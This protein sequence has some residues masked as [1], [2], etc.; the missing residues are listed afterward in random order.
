MNGKKIYESRN[1]NNR[2]ELKNLIGKPTIIEIPQE[3]FIIGKNIL[4]IRT[5]TI[6]NKSGFVY[7]LKIG[8]QKLI[9]NY[10]M[11]HII[12]YTLL[13]A[14]NIFIT[15]YFLFIYIY[16]REAF[17][18]HFSL[19]SLSL[20]IWTIGYHGLNLYL[21]DNQITYIISTYICAIIVCIFYITF[22]HSFLKISYNIFSYLLLTVM[23]LLLFFSCAEM[24]I[25]THVFHY[26]R[27]LFKIFILSALLVVFYGDVICIVGKIQKKPY[28]MRIFS[29]TF[30]L[31][32]TYAISI[33]SFLEITKIQPPVSEGFFLLILIFASTIAS[34]FAQVH[35]DL[36]TAHADLL[37]LDKM[38]D[39]F[40]STTTHEL[41]TPL[42]GIMGIAESLF[43][44]SLGEV[45]L[46]QKDNIN[47]IRLSAGRLNNLVTSILDFSKLQAGRA[48]LFIDEVSLADVIPSVVSLLQASVK[49]KTI[50]FITDI[51]PL[52]TIHADRNRIHQIL[53]NLVGNAIKFT[54]HGSV[55]VRAAL[56][57]SD[58]VRVE[59]ADTGPGI[60][61]E[62]LARIW[63]P[64]ARGGD[65]DTRRSGGAGLG[66][67][68]TRHL[69]EL[70]GGKI[71]AESEE[72]KGSVFIFEIP[73]EARIAGIDRARTKQYD[74]TLPT[75]ARAVPGPVVEQEAAPSPADEPGK[76]IPAHRSAPVLLAVDDD[77]VNLKVIENL[78]RSRGYVVLTA[79]DGPAALNILESTG[80]DLVLLDLMLPGMSG[81]D[82]CR[83]IR[84]MEKG[85][86][87]PV[88]MV[89]ARDQL[90]D[91]AQGFKTG[92]NDYITK[93][94]KQQELVLRIENQLAIKQMLDMEKSIGTDHKKGK[95]PVAG[96]LERS[97][98]LKESALQ[99]L[100]REKII[101][102]DLG[103]ARA[104]QERLMTR[105]DGIDGFEMS[106]HFHPLMEVGGD[107]Y[108]IFQIRPGTVRVFLADATG[109]GITA[110]LNTVKILS[111]YA[112]VKETLGSPADIINF[113]N[114]RFTRNLNQYGIVFTCIIADVS[115]E[116]SSVTI[117]SSGMP[118]QFIRRGG[119]IAV[120][121]PMNPIIGLS[122]K[123]A[124]REE[125]HA[126]NRGDV[127]FIYS[128]GLLEMIEDFQKR[129]AGGGGNSIETLAD[130]IA[131]IYPGT[132]LDDSGNQILKRF[133][134]VKNISI[135]D[136]TF[137]AIKKLT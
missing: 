30:A 33:F 16:R 86:Y 107:V 123:T 50:E 72:G 10:F 19:L 102:E 119:E 81:Y 121:D 87:L 96:L 48:D 101:K 94:F 38:K 128:D 65:A 69:V 43:D 84:R 125:T 95:R 13:T 60:A 93:P 90:G 106:V 22:I 39:D 55:T 29:G 130:S 133:G 32:L 78:C 131:T 75:G 40:L 129:G 28:S 120:I 6:D 61:R 58:T 122:S 46:R 77:P 74:L 26:T 11:R 135:D 37:V 59:V 116:S 111:E 7:P 18:L 108:D 112:A 49:D 104:F 57:G 137:I 92:A 36:E 76:V 34:R 71:W 53:I 41:R 134:G 9:F 8:P 12:W 51:G 67:P 66:L 1:F 64:F 4:A 68:I 88:I 23:T 132:S 47:L 62:D 70:H 83:T 85:R 91:L 109:H 15:I 124:Y 100:E 117:S 82:V 2:S 80:I 42:H 45:N 89:T 105:E 54:D 17:Y 79:A 99:M 3:L 98:D 44:G 24:L 110:S 73:V 126:L 56:A 103:I 136:V 118:S 25:T 20:G 97:K 27:H 127:L 21:F 52:P 114:Q 115:L 14:V 63:I 113:L 31:S 35:T 5:G